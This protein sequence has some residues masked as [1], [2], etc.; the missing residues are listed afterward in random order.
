MSFSIIKIIESTEQ[1]ISY[2]LK[3]FKKYYKRDNSCLIISDNLYKDKI[4]ENFKKRLDFFTLNYE[5][6]CINIWRHR[7]RRCL[8]C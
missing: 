5:K 8:P 3:L 4:K 7:P 6:N 2:N 1:Y